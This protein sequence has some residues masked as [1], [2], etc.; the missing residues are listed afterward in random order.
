M[1]VENTKHVC[2][3]KRKQHPK[4]TT[5]LLETPQAISV[6]TIEKDTTLDLYG[7]GSGTIQVLR[8]GPYTESD[9]YDMGFEISIPVYNNCIHKNIK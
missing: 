6:Q 2:L 1:F 7:T 8:D 3:V 5:G 9:F 4:W